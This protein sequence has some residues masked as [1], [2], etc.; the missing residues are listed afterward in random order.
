MFSFT[1]GFLRENVFLWKLPYIYT[2]GIRLLCGQTCSSCKCCYDKWRTW[3]RN[4]VQIIWGTQKLKLKS[5]KESFQMDSWI[6]A[7]ITAGAQRDLHWERPEALWLQ[8]NIFLWKTCQI[9]WLFE[10]MICPKEVTEL[11][12]KIHSYMNASSLLCALKQ[13]L[14]RKAEWCKELINAE[15]LLNRKFDRLT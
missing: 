1:A 9:S 11:Q 12:G 2:L 13:L 8:K 14:S 4:L 15:K 10:V 5:P 6:E 7:L 3:L